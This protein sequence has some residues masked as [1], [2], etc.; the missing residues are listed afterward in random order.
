MQANEGTSCSLTKG[1]HGVYP[2]KVM[3]STKR[4]DVGLQES[5]WPL[6]L[7][8]TLRELNWTKLG[9]SLIRTA[10]CFTPE[11]G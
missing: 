7:D 10:D 11:F 8:D 4:S 9:V 5:E 2:G 3:Q 6:T 1:G